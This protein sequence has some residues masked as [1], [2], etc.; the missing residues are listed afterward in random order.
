MRSAGKRANMLGGRALTPDSNS[1][2]WSNMVQG[3]L[4]LYDAIR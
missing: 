3:Q 1:P 4:N 2:T